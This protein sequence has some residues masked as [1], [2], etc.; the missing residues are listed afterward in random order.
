MP[1]S[2]VGT[3]GAL[4]RILWQ[5]N[6]LIS[7]APHQCYRTSKLDVHFIYRMSNYAETTKTMGSFP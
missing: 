6:D 4:A 1:E 7:L 2:Y 3:V 5:E